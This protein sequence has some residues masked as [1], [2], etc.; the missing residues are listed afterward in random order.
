MDGLQ[1]IVFWT[2]YNKYLIEMIKHI[3]EEKLHFGCLSRNN[4]LLT[5]EF[6]INDY[7]AHL[8]HH[9]QQVVVY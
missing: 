1:I 5:L 3:P 9:L 8:E 7:V 2:A 6:L 4:D